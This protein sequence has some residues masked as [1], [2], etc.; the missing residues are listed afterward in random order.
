MIASVEDML[1]RD[2][3][4][5]YKAYPDPLSPYAVAARKGL[6][7]AGLDG[8]PWTIGEGHTGPEVHEGLVWDDTQIDDA[9]Q[10]DV[11][12]AWTDCQNHFEPWLSQLNDARQAVLVCMTYQMGI[13]R[14]LGF[15]NT[16]ASVRDQHFAN[17]AEGMRQSL[18]AKQTHDRAF[19]YALQMELG[20]FQ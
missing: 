18:W 19:R 15:V 14:L 12:E 10:L 17:A 20:A 5:E 6:P 7:T 3:G 9:K 2:E 8:S 16:L 1:R 11:A 4:R 13:G